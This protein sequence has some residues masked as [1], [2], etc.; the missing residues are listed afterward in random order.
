MA[1]RAHSSCRTSCP[2][3]SKM[4][5]FRRTKHRVAACLFRSTAKMPTRRTLRDRAQDRSQEAQGAARMLGSNL[6]SGYSPS[7]ES[8][9]RVTSVNR[10]FIIAIRGDSPFE[11][12]VGYAQ[13][14]TTPWTVEEAATF[15]QLTTTEQHNELFTLA[16]ALGLRRGE[17]LGLRWEDIDLATRKLHVRQTAQ[18]LGASHGMVI[19]PPKSARSR[20]PFR[21]RHRCGETALEATVSAHR[22]RTGR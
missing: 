6:A 4:V 15:L 14:H 11:I 18:R 16:L 3:T 12:G 19:G 22:A 21:F 20:R 8:R 13:P 7:D 17:L 5:T 9:T 10:P 2:T 1:L